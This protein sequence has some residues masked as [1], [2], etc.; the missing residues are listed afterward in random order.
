MKGV[1]P[2]VDEVLRLLLFFVDLNR[3]SPFCE[4]YQWQKSS[5]FTVNVCKNRP[6][7]QQLFPKVNIALVVDRYSG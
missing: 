7:R 5:Q 3:Y 1:T 4:T 2:D 6:H